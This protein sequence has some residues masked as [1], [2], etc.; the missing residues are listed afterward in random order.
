M[1][2]ESADATKQLS[3]GYVDMTVNGTIPGLP[4]KNLTGDLTNTPARAAKGH[5]QVNLGGAAV[6]MDFVV[7]DGMLYGSLDPGS[8]TDF[9]SASSIYDATA[10]LNPDIGL[11]N[12]LS[13]FTNPK[14]EGRETINGV[15]TVKITGQV[16]ADAANKIAPKIASSTTVPSTVWIREDGNHDLVQA[17]L[18]ALPNSVQ[19]TLSKWNEPVTVEKPPGV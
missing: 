2:R 3:S 17:T 1:L 9:G 13:N 19:F 7:L 10:I 18:Q 5:L 8:W 14:T 11:A 4:I 12:I 15:Q 16:S 6:D